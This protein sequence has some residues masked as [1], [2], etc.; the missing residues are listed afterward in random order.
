MVHNIT[1]ASKAKTKSTPQVSLGSTTLGWECVVAP[2]NSLAQPESSSSSSSPTM[3]SVPELPRG[4]DAPS[5][6]APNLCDVVREALQR[7]QVP[8]EN[9]SFYLSEVKNCARY[10]R[11]FQKLW[12]FCSSRG[13]DPSTMTTFEAASWLL[14]FTERSPH[15]ARNAYAGLL[16][17]PGWE[18]L[19]FC[20]LIKQCKVKWQAKGDKYSDFWDAKRLLTVL[21]RTP[22]SWSSVQEV[23]DRCIIIMRIL[24]LCRSVDLA[25]LLRR[26][27]A[28]KGSTWISIRRKGQPRHRFEKLI[29]LNV[30]A[31]SPLHLVNHYVTL[32]LQ[33][34]KPGGPMFLALQPP[35][36][37][38]SSSSLGSITKKVLTKLGVPTQ[39]FGP[40]STRGAGVSMYKE[41]GFP[42]E[43]VC[44]IGGWKNVQAFL[45]T[46]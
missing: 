41:F 3:G 16:L 34:G 30:E 32:T 17:I 5:P 19:R 11:A 18:S 2:L 44:E 6:V 33:Q 29:V 15:E 20:T 24:H 4:I 40:H 7:K 31:V 42:S 8:S 21:V 10:N 13:A 1:L 27:A 25:R 14:Q 38:L 35:Y 39:F 37:P 43:T 28:S 12:Q 36:K 23:R 45:R 22:L 46:T 26:K 9:I